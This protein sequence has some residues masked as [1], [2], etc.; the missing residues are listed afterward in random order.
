MGQTGRVDSAVAKLSISVSRYSSSST[1][2]CLRPYFR[3]EI[4][5]AVRSYV[6]PGLSLA[7]ASQSPRGTD[8]MYICA[9][10]MGFNSSMASF[11]ARSHHWFP[12]IL[13][14]NT[15]WK[16]IAGDSMDRNDVFNLANC[17]QRR[18]SR[19]MPSATHNHPP[20]T[21]LNLIMYPGTYVVMPQILA[22]MRW[23]CCRFST[24]YSGCSASISRDKSDEKSVSVRK[25]RAP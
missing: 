14:R 8:S 21:C 2:S 24:L 10:G 22:A 20:S 11:G 23:V 12:N 6:V 7:H 9:C 15:R 25:A 17:T 19:L 1:A 3:F 5:K 4:V 18:V 16:S 13:L